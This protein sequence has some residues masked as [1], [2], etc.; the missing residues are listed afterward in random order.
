MESILERDKKSANIE[1]KKKIKKVNKTLLKS[2]SLVLKPTANIFNI[3]DNFNIIQEQQINDFKFSKS[4]SMKEKN[5]IST[6][7][8]IY[9][10][11]N[12]QGHLET[13]LETIS[14][15]SNSKKESKDISKKQNNNDETYGLYKKWQ[16]LLK[17]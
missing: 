4:K 6:N 8:Y 12:L 17:K 3:N 14:E 2:N 1:D 13:V 16:N 10:F 5:L 15:V 9:H 11:N 7:N